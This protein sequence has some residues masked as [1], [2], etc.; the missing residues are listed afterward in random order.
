MQIDVYQK[1]YPEPVETE[2]VRLFMA[3]FSAAPRYEEWDEQSAREAIRKDYDPDAI[4]V[5]VSLDDHLVGF[6]HGLPISKS[7]IASEI[8]THAEELDGF[9]LSNIAVDETMIAQ[10]FGKILLDAFL[11]EVEKT[12]ATCVA[13]AREDALAVRSL[14]RNKGFSEQG[15]YQAAVGS[16]IAWR[17]FY[18]KR[19]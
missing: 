1:R 6:C 11:E 7:A 15:R 2:V 3:A 5:A 17:Y 4:F 9:Y 16:S 13:R 8:A 10:G 18:V 12:Y 19:F 14:F